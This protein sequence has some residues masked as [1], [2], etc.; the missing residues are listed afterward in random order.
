M[1]FSDDCVDL[2][3]AKILVVVGGSSVAAAAR[4][5]AIPRPTNQLRIF[6]VLR[7]STIGNFNPAIR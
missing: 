2:E 7:I 6:F 3:D 4:S 5:V 1:G